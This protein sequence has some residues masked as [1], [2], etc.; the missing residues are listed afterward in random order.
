MRRTIVCPLLSA[1]PTASLAGSLARGVGSM[2][3]GALVLAAIAAPMAAQTLSDSFRGLFTFGD[4]GEPLCLDVAAAVHGDHY[5]PSITQGENDLLAFITGSVGAALGNLPF[6]AATGGVTYRFEEGLPV[7][8][9]VSP[10]PIFAER[11]LT[12]GHRRGVVGVNVNGI[13]FS[14]IRGVSL[15]DLDLTFTHQNVGDPAMGDPVFENDLIEVGVDMDIRVIVTSIFASYGLTDGLDVS[16]QLPVVHS[17]VSGSSRADIIH[18]DQNSPHF[19]LSPTGEPTTAATS[20]ADN[21]ALGIGDIAV[22]MKAFLVETEWGGVSVLGDLRLPTGDDENFH[23]AGSASFRLMGVGSGQFGDF[24]PHLN[25]GFVTRGGW[26][27][28]NSL[29]VVAGFDHILSEVATLAVEILGDFQVED[30]PLGLPEPVVFTAP[31]VRTVELHDIPDRADHLLD[32]A[33]GL[34]FQAPGDTRIVTGALFPFLKGGARPTF[35]W[36]IGLERSF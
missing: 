25:L 2:A 8:T 34:K 5:N 23:G 19:F 3:A 36:T 30:S 17:S 21:S 31:T 26:N 16:V 20:S 33:F 9:S 1:S 22:R 12:L 29:L 15:N 14:S 10:G 27:Q 7:A 6:A 35:Q 32:L 13:S 4:C 24:S 11:A 18:W 28:T